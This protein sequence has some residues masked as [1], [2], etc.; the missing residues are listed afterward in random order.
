[1]TNIFGWL[2]RPERT[3]HNSSRNFMNYKFKNTSVFTTVVYAA[4][5]MPIISNAEWLFFDRFAFTFS[6]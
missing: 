2:T 5:A 1:V 3:G 4:V 6:Y